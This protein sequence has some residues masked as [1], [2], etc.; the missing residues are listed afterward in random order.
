MSELNYTEP[1]VGS[2]INLKL[3]DRA[4]SSQS[5]T[6]HDDYKRLITNL[7]NVHATGMLHYSVATNSFELRIPDP[8]LLVQD[9]F[10]ELNSKHLYINLL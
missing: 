4:L 5:A 3:L 1:I 8:V 10:K 2:K 7:L 9:G 6:L